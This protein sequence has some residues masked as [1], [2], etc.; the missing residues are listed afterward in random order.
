ME[1]IR[2]VKMRERRE[3]LDAEFSAKEVSGGKRFF[4]PEK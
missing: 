3:C 1:K 4:A 2:S